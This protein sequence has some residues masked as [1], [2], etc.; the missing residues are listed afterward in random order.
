MWP[1]GA[2]LPNPFNW[3]RARVLYALVPADACMWK[4]LRVRVRVNPNT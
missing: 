3:L 4:V 1:K 2:C